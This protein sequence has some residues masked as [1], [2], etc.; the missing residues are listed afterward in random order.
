MVRTNERVPLMVTYTKNLP[1]IQAIGHNRFQII[2]R[3]ERLQ[4][5]FPKP[6]ITAF[7]RDLNLNDMLIHSEHNKIF[8]KKKPGTIYCGN[9]CAI[10]HHRNGN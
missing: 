7:R 1:N 6:P 2:N 5:V 9:K 4:K 8:E 10:C 3:S